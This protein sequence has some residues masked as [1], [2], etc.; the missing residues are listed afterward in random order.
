MERETGR[1]D[2]SKGDEFRARATEMMARALSEKHP[3][4][5]AK[6]EELS[7]ILHRLADEADNEEMVKTKT[8]PE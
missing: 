1:F 6:F 3:E 7:H 5:R 2:M 4:I 8:S